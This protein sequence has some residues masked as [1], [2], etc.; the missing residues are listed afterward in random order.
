MVDSCR[1]PNSTFTS[2]KKTCSH[3]EAEFGVIENTICA[4]LRHF[5][6]AIRLVNRKKVSMPSVKKLTSLCMRVAAAEATAKLKGSRRQLLLQHVEV[7]VR[8]EERSKPGTPQY[9]KQHAS[10]EAI[11]RV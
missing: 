8:R 10:Y 6:S 3:D 5:E 7:D 1:S 9:S 2:S 11:V 4:A